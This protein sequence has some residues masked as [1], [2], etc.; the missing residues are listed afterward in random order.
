MASFIDDVIV[1]MEMKEE[2]DEIVEEV[3]KR[4][5]K[6]D[7]YV[8]LEKYKWKVKEVGFLGVIIELER[9]KIEEEKVKSILDWLTPKGVQDI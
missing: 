7:L 6:N 3:V 2:Y 5:A 8:K 9:I 1:G 4:L